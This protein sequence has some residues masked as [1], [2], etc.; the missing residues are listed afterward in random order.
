MTSWKPPASGIGVQ[1]GAGFGIHLLDFMQLRLGY[2]L[3]AT[4]AANLV[5]DRDF[6]ND[7]YPRTHYLP[8]L[9]DHRIEIR[10]SHQS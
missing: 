8:H 9:L 10:L 1:A 6:G 7:T 4:L 2:R 5:E 3:T